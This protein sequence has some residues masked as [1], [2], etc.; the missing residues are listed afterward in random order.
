MMLYD[1]EGLIDDLNRRIKRSRDLE[2]ME[3]LSVIL[4]NITE[5]KNNYEGKEEKFDPDKRIGVR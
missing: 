2:E 5:A 4:K 3:K 1:F